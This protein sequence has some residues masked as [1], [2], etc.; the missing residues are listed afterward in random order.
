MINQEP[1]NAKRNDITSNIL[2]HSL[3]NIPFVGLRPFRTEES[4]LFFGQHN[5]SEKVI[6]KLQANKFVCLLGGA[7]VGKT[8][9]INCDIKPWLYSGFAYDSNA[10]WHIFDSQPGYD[11]IRNLAKSICSEPNDFFDENKP[12]LEQISYS[13]LRRGK[14]GIHELFEQLKLPTNTNYLFVIDQ[15]EDLFRTRSKTDEVDFFEEALEFVILLLEGCNDKEYNIYVIVSIRSDFTDD[16]VMFPALAEM[17]NRSNVLIPK[18]SRNQIQQ[19]ILGPLNTLNIKIDKTCLAQILNDATTA[20]DL[21]P[22]LQHA[23]K[24]TWESW[25][26]LHSADKPISIKEYESVGGIQGSIAA[27][28]NFVFDELNDNDRNTCELIFKSLTERGSE[29]KGLTRVCSVNELAEIAMVEVADIVRIV[30]IFS[31]PEIGFL[32]S[33]TPDIKPETFV[34]LSHVSLMRAWNNLRQWVDDEA[35]SG[36]MFQQLSN[37]SAAYQIGRVGLLR[38]PDLQFAIN[39][40]EKQK[41]TNAWAKRYSLAFERTMVYLRTSLNSFEAEEAL[42]KVQA[43]KAIRKVRSLSII[44]GTTA[45]LAMMV[46]LYS[47]VLRRNAETQKRL[48]LYQMQEADSKSITAEKISKEALEDKFHAEIAANEAEKNKLQALQETEVLSQQKSFAEITAQ[49][50]VKKTSET[51]LNLIEITKQN[52]QIEKAALQAS[53]QKTEAE[54]EKEETFKKR[55]LTI[56]QA[57]AV[58]SSQVLNNKTLKAL[59]A[60]QAY[61]FNTKY[62]GIDCHPDIYNALFNSLSDNGINL[63]RKFKGHTGSVKALCVN[64]NTNIMYSTGSDGKV[65]AWNLN[66]ADVPATTYIKGGGGNLSLAISQNGRLL[67]VGSEVGNIQIIDLINP[68]AKPVQLKAHQGAVYSITFSKDG[69]QLFSTGADKKILLWDLATSSP[70]VIYNEGNTVRALSIS[71]DGKFLASGAEDGRVLVWDIRNNQMVTFGGDDRNPVYAVSFNYSGTLLASGDIKGNVK[72]WNPYSKKLI[73][74][75]KSHSARVVDIK[76]SAKSDLMVSS[77]YD[78]SVYIFDTRYVNAPPI[79]VREPATW[80]LSVALSVDNK[81]LIMATN[82]PDFIIS[83]PSQTKYM[84]DLLCSKITR[85]LTNDEWNTYIG[86]DLKYEKTCE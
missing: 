2:T 72:L 8:S 38:P 47:Q 37:A 19:A 40:R 64:S 74:S 71:P 55:L 13:V 12:I 1:A 77:S 75:F 52:Q 30:S 20:D 23:M 44:L 36:Q 6:A 42:K 16:C 9:L 63:R 46:M 80:I 28:A 49:E 57:I 70:S 35:I 33:D 45:I 21:L 31:H 5:T 14:S 4:H 58:K 18:M 15:F 24:R 29:N 41:P 85:D 67:A 69:Q 78:G 60:A 51:E 53:L 54:K 34:Q 68:T 81:Y 66:E 11:P 73:K 32:V 22:R 3:P 25:S 27:H 79:I 43:K 84:A 17:I 59:L 10:N 39:W 50:A 82:K 26:S 65:I 56:S 61:Q 48:A 62:G 7:G 83:V 76:F 86:S